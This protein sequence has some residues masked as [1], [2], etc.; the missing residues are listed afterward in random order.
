[1]GC[2]G[3][4]QDWAGATLRRS[5]YRNTT[6]KRLGYGGAPTRARTGLCEKRSSHRSRI[7]TSSKRRFSRSPRSY[8]ARIVGSGSAITASRLMKPNGTWFP[9]GGITSI[10]ESGSNTSSLG[11]TGHR[12][13]TCSFVIGATTIHCGRRASYNQTLQRVVGNHCGWQI[14]TCGFRIG[15]RVNRWACKAFL[16]LCWAP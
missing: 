14:L 4:R 9:R 6:M 10:A 15:W 13:T 11:H 7:R 1:M 3:P 16:S 2:P 8:H 5:G 12:A